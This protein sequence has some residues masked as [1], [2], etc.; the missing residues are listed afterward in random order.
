MFQVLLKENTTKTSSVI[1][2]V[3]SFSRRRQ[4]RASRMVA[5]KLAA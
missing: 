1:I 5:R 3:D 4:R 2:A